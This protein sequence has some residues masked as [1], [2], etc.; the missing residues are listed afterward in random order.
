MSEATAGEEGCAWLLFFFFL[1]F[2]ATPAAYRSSWAK[3]WIRT[4]AATWATAVRSLAHVPQQELSTF[5]FSTRIPLANLALQ[6]F[7]VIFD[8]AIL[9]QNGTKCSVYFEFPLKCN[10]VYYCM[11]SGKQINGHIWMGA[12]VSRLQLLL[13]PCHNQNILLKYF[14]NERHKSSLAA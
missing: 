9:M 11:L 10:V 7:T 2:L 4:T 8:K 6:N 3:D 1:S 14:K 5:S 13:A 12:I